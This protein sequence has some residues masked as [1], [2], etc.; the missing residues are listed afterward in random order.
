MSFE[1]IDVGEQPGRGAFTRAEADAFLVFIDGDEVDFRVVAI[2][3]PLDAIGQR[4]VAKLFAT[5]FQIQFA[6]E[7]LKRE[8]FDLREPFVRFDDQFVKRAKLAGLD[9]FRQRAQPGLEKI[10]A[11]IVTTFPCLRLGEHGKFSLDQ[12]ITV[13]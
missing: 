8:V 13:D 11:E 2:P 10:V 4:K 1:I 5:P 3:I 7:F 12:A 6:D 9:R